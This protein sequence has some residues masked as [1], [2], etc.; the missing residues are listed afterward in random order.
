MAE[1]SKTNTES[2]YLSHDPRIITSSSQES[3]E[4]KL[5]ADYHLNREEIRVITEAYKLRRKEL[6]LATRKELQDFINQDYRA[7][8]EEALG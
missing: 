6:F 4:S 1:T 3:L 5:I 2:G 7:A 8:N